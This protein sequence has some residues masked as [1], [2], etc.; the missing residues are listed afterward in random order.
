MASGARAGGAAT[1]AGTGEL[2]RPST[3]DAAAGVGLTAA[4]DRARA[5]ADAGRHLAGVDLLRR[6]LASAPSDPGR[7]AATALLA[8]LLA[9]A[10]EQHGALAVWNRTLDEDPDDVEAL[11][12][13]A[14]VAP[15]L[16]DAA[17]RVLHAVEIRALTADEMAAA[18]LAL[19]RGPSPPATEALRRL[20]GQDGRPPPRLAVWL[21]ATALM[22]GD[23]ATTVDVLDTALH[24]PVDDPGVARHGRGLRLRALVLAG[25]AAQAEADADAVLAA[26]QLT[27]HERL[28]VGVALL[29][30]GRAEEAAEQLEDLASL[31]PEQQRWWALFSLGNARALVDEVDAATAALT[32]A[33]EAAPADRAASLRGEA[34]SLV[35]DAH[36]RR[37]E[38]ADAIETLAEALQ[39]GLPDHLIAPL[40]AQRG[41]LLQLAGRHVEASEDLRTALARGLPGLLRTSTAIDLAESLLL[42]GE[43]ERARATLVELEAVTPDVTQDARFWCVRGE[44]AFASDD[45]ASLLQ[46]IERLEGLGPA[47]AAHALLMR[48]S[49]AAASGDWAELERLL[50]EAVRD[51]ADPTSADGWLVAGIVRLQLARPDAGS[52]VQRALELAPGLATSPLGRL[53]Q[54][55]LAIADADLPAFDAAAADAAP[56]EQPLLHRLRAQ[57]LERLG[58][59]PAA[60]AELGRV[61]AAVGTASPRTVHHVAALA[62]VQAACLLVADDDDEAAAS[63]LGEARQ[64]LVASRTPDGAPAVLVL[65]WE[66][67]LAAREGRTDAALEAVHAARRQLDRLPVALRAAVDLAEAQLHRLSGDD[68]QA[69]AVL[70]VSAAGAPTA[71][72]LGLL[73]EVQLSLGDA[74][75]A[76]AS[77]TR[78]LELDGT[79]AGELLRQRS[80]ARLAAGLPEWALE[81]ARAALAVDDGAA[82]RLTLARVYEELGRL[83]QAGAAY[84][85]A[86][87]AAREDATAARAL[88]GLSRVLLLQGQVG[89]VLSVLDSGAGRRLGH[90]WGAVAY[91]RG[92]ALLRAGRR[93]EAVDELRRAA[94]AE[95]PV[96]GADGIADRVSAAVVRAGSYVGYWFTAAGPHRRAGGAVLVVLLVAAA[97]LAVADPAQVGWLRWASA[98]AS[99]RLVPLLAL[100]ALLLAPVV[101]RLKVGAVEVEQPAPAAVEL[102]DLEPSEPEDVVAAMTAAVRR[103][104]EQTSLP[105]LTSPLVGPMAQGEHS[106]RRALVLPDPGDASRTAAVGVTAAKPAGA[107]LPEQRPPVGVRAGY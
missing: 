53:A 36:A 80:V 16:D 93:A 77:A 65:L 105:A 24:D 33:V 6:V 51:P 49:A 57:L 42:T 43:V 7:R 83:P 103:A 62:L 29:H 17:E 20:A 52:A 5:A 102:P 106:G 58:D 40:R 1:G 23:L 70:R 74:D 4:V 81:D 27:P 98:D 39:A 2:T 55:S 3:T 13:S 54:L 97:G 82:T 60:V 99:A 50:T 61:A 90:T 35:A 71:E 14:A 63:A 41:M 78:A 30:S 86:V 85:R 32:A 75:A 89:E 31:L 45:P 37:G 64:H 91:N 87:G 10:G 19:S 9:D 8:R 28:E 38:L 100:T 92:V 107:T 69:L 68:E 46:A 56:L 15:G 48:F 34:A 12:L 94:R 21:A 79:R 101:T 96:A 25:R 18:L 76:V 47:L 95:H 66:A 67:L 22:N 72:L 88:V 26:G 44:M 73:A 84:R 59:R 11:L 104:V